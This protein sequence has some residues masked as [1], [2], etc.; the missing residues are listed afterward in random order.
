MISSPT[1][2]YTG[3]TKSQARFGLQAL[4]ERTNI[5]INNLMVLTINMNTSNNFYQKI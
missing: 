2:F 3:L 4:S 5:I 1:F